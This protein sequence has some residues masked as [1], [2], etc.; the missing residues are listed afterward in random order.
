MYRIERETRGRRRR[1]PG[2]GRRR[3]LSLAALLLALAIG[4]GLFWLARGWLGGREPAQEGADQG[5]YEGKAP[6]DCP[7]W[8]RQDFL[9]LNEYSRPGKKLSTVNGIVVH[10]VGNPGTTAEQNHSYFT[11]LAKTGETYAS[12]HFL[13][14]LD[15]SILQNM[16]LDEVAYCSNE[17]NGDTLAIEC[18]HP[19]ESGAFTGETYDALVK[20][21]AWLVEYYELDAEQ[22]IRHYDVTGKEC[23]RHFVE[24]PEAWETFLEDVYLPAE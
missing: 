1:P 10:Y 21:T 15:G 14:D 20:L 13:I 11:N 18:C 9:P 8:I 17:R 22:V 16:P 19:D 5:T 2:S 12:S 3:W 24:D 4:G 23:P 6:P 7:D